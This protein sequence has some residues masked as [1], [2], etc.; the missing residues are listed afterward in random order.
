MRYTYL[1]DIKL[2]RSGVPY[3]V[4]QIAHR[5]DPGMMHKPANYGDHGEDRR[6]RGPVVAGFLYL[7]LRPENL[8]FAPTRAHPKVPIRVGFSPVKRSAPSASVSMLR[9][10]VP[11]LDMRLELSVRRTIANST[12][13]RMVPEN[14]TRAA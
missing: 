14:S 5:E 8:G 6:N 12:T 1:T 10:S 4:P 11:F 13:M 7:L 3:A 2:V 9:G